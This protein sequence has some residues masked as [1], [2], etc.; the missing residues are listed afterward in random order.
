MQGGGGKRLD[1]WWWW[2]LLGVPAPP[3]PPL[4]ELLSS[5]ELLNPPLDMWKLLPELERGPHSAGL[6]WKHGWDIFAEFFPS[7]TFC[8]NL[9]MKKLVWQD[10]SCVHITQ[11]TMN[12]LSCCCNPR[13]NADQ[14]VEYQEGWCDPILD[15]YGPT[16]PFWP[17]PTICYAHVQC[18]WMWLCRTMFSR[19]CCKIVHNFTCWRFLKGPPTSPS[20]PSP[21]WFQTLCVL[22]KGKELVLTPG[23]FCQVLSERYIIQIIG[24]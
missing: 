15:H 14:L 19:H 12:I 5:A 9:I 4:R 11:W 21:L 7:K 8:L 1:P 2:Q 20:W 22:S 6:I 18:P 24:C 23:L 17:Y 3:R 13:P 10:V 16:M